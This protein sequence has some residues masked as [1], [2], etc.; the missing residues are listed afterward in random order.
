MRRLVLLHKR[1]RQN[2]LDTVV[3]R[4][5]HDQAVDTH[6]PTTSRRQTVLQAGAEV[7]VDDL[8]LVVT[9]V[10]LVGLLLETQTLVERVVQLSVGIN[11]LL[12]T[13]EGLESL[14]ETGMLT[15]VF[16][17]W[18]H[19]LRVAE[20]KGGVDTG[21][22]DELAHELV[23]H[24][25]VGER[26]RALD[27][28]LLEHALEK[29]ARLSGVELVTWGKLLAG[30]F[31]EGWDHLYAPPGGLPVH[32]VGLACLGVEGGLVAAGDVLDETRNE[33][34]CEVHEVES[35]SVCLIKFAGS[36][37]GVVSKVN[38]FVSELTAH[39]IHTLKT[40]DNQHLQVQL[41][42]NTHKQVHVEF[43]VVGNE[44][45]RSR[46]T[47]NGIH[48]WGLD[49][50]EVTRVEE[51]SDVANNLSPGDKDITRLVVHDQVQV[52]LAEPLLLIL[53]TKVLGRD[54]VQ[55]WRQQNDFPRENRKLTVG[56]VL[57]TTPTRETDDTDNVTSPEVL[58]LLFKGNIASGVL[59]LAKN[60]YL[61]TLCADVVEVQLGARTTL[62]VDSTRNA[63]GDFGL[64]LALLETLVVLQELAQV[65]GDV[66]LVGVR[67]GLFGLA[68][69]VDSLA[70]DF[71]V[72]LCT[73]CVS[74]LSHPM[75]SEHK[76]SSHSVSG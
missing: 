5:E 36:E 74:I 56:P 67:V 27:A 18:R 10:L 34:L 57:G 13:D 38:A 21:L 17:Q 32:V 68:E 33:L 25:G 66:E 69:L 61:H 31:L 50:R 47:G 65:V 62:G 71:E 46:A 58:V 19:H 16:G 11:D 76:T 12:L 6:T 3:I 7:L 49:L 37:L 2:L 39:L 35:V 55:A 60:L 22:F 28:G 59:T 73:T 26:W 44:R 43:V 45:P 64:L 24:T 72:L 9:L 29:F 40:T 8:G 70:S 4:E 54:G 52:P 42:R 75:E 41:R 51:V 1:E 14:A 30:G 20:N 48:H 23:E 63:D 53:Q 15:V